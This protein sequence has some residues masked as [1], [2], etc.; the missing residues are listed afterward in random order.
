EHGGDQVQRADVARFV[1]RH[2]EPEILQSGL[3]RKDFREA[4][5]QSHALFFQC[6]R[7]IEDFARRGHRAPMI[8]SGFQRGKARRPHLRCQNDKPGPAGAEHRRFNK[9]F[10]A[11][12]TSIANGTVTTRY[13]KNV[14]A[15]SATR[16]ANGPATRE[17]TAT[18]LQARNKIMPNQMGTAGHTSR[19]FSVTMVRKPSRRKFPSM[20]G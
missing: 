5:V 10:I 19:M 17:S 12:R 2:P 18:E 16:A 6:D 1:T 20:I 9:R 8:P 13:M 4:C 14:I 3:A 15:I 11:I 7:R